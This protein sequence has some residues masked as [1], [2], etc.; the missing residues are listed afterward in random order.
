M[1]NKIAMSLM[2]LGALFGLLSFVYAPSVSAV[3]GT[4][5]I[6]AKNPN[7]WPCEEGKNEW[8]WVITQVDAGPKPDVIR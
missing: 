2:A 6:T 7:P 8:H 3:E 4:V 1:R 5:R